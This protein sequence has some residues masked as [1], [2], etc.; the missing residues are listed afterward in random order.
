MGTRVLATVCSVQGSQDAASEDASLAS[1]MKVRMAKSRADVRVME[2]ARRHR[3]EC[4]GMG[5]GYEGEA[6]M[7]KP[8]AAVVP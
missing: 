1:R 8:S 2:T 6:I 7:K 3:G 5:E 4:A